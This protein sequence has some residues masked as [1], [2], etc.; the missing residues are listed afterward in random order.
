MF[1]H[2]VLIKIFVEEVFLHHRICFQKKNDTCLDVY[3]LIHKKYIC[4]IFCI[5]AIFLHDC[6]ELSRNLILPF[7]ANSKTRGVALNTFRWPWKIYFKTSIYC[8]PLCLKLSR[9]ML[10]TVKCMKSAAVIV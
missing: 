6:D 2:T 10:Q 7:I 8:F 4:N 1:M 5:C 9:K 3:H